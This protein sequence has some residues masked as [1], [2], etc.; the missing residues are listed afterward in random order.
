MTVPDSPGTFRNR[1]PQG[2]ATEFQALRAVLGVSARWAR[3]QPLT[4]SS[5][6]PA[7]NAAIMGHMQ[8]F[9]RVRKDC[10]RL[11]PG[12]VKAGAIIALHLTSAAAWA[13]RGV[14]LPNEDK[15]FLQWGVGLGLGVLICVSAFLNSKRSHQD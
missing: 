9:D 7:N 6:Y 4:E 10:T 14:A 8:G 11:R 2:A 5:L 15:G 3:A 13:Q 1:D 12:L